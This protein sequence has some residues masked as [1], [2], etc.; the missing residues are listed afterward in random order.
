M[1]DP[2]KVI[3]SSHIVLAAYNL[4]SFL[5]FTYLYAASEKEKNMTSNS[6]K[7]LVSLK[8]LQ[9]QLFSLELCTNTFVQSP[10]ISLV[11]NPHVHLCFCALTVKLKP[12]YTMNFICV[13]VIDGLHFT[14]I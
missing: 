12:V 8:T 14:S 9:L 1:L 4:C 13:N 2:I 6:M 7:G 3:N 5:L 11:S 10:F